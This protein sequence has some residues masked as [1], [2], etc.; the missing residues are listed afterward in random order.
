SYPGPDPSAAHPLVLPV[1]L[2]RHLDA[3]LGPRR[4]RRSDRGGPEDRSRRG[5]DPHH[6]HLRPRLRTQHTSSPDTP[7]PLQNGPSP[8]IGVRDGSPCGSTVAGSTTV[9][10]HSSVVSVEISRTV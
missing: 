3:T 5:H 1:L 7:P 6:R 9:L 8:R 4:L 10:P 2:G